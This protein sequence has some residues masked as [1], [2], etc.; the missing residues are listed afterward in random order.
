LIYETTPFLLAGE[1]NKTKTLDPSSSREKTPEM[2]SATSTSGDTP[3]TTTPAGG[4]GGAIARMK[5]LMLPSSFLSSASATTT[6]SAA[7]GAT[8]TSGVSEGRQ[9]EGDAWSWVLN[10]EQGPLLGLGPLCRV[11]SGLPLDGPAQERALLCVGVASQVHCPDD[12]RGQESEV[13]RI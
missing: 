10:C 9:E 2:N 1:P 12:G 13:N 3:E 8:E 4:G 7:G 5:S 11:V 6:S